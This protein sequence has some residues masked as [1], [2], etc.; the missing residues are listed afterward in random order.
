LP[1]SETYGWRFL[2][3]HLRGAGRDD[4]A[5]RLLINYEWIRAKLYAGDAQTLFELYLPESSAEAAQLVS[6]A[7]ALSL[8]ALAITRRECASRPASE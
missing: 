6:R 4:E 7:I 3:R 5:D 8:P 2:V 1:P